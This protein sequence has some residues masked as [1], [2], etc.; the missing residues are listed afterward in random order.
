M[1]NKIKLSILDFVHIYN[2]SSVKEGIE[3]SM[4]VLAKA[5]ELGFTR[6][7]FTEHHN[8]SSLASTSPAMLIMLAGQ[9]SKRI[10]IGAGG[11]MLPNHSA[12]RIA[13]DFT[14]LE[15]LYPGR[16][17]L[18]IGR[19]PGTDPKTHLELAGSNTSLDKKLSDL[20]NYFGRSFPHKDPLS[21]ITIPGDK[22]LTPNIVMLGSS[23]G[24]VQ[25]AIRDGLSFSFAAH[26]NP[27]AAREVLRFYKDNYRPK[28]EGDKPYSI[29]TTAVIVGK[30]QEEAEYLAG[31]AQ[32]MWIRLRNGKGNPSYPSL[33]EAANYNY[34]AQDLMIK[35]MNKD[36][37]IIGTIDTVK[38]QFDKILEETLADEI[39]IAD[40][41]PTLD[42]RLEA[43]ELLTELL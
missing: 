27:P 2:D 29:Y 23:S 14:T 18:G 5:D 10:N 19:A 24:G 39:M 6:Y 9:Y 7:W 1:S 16:V 34:T 11:V 13:E 12:L 20:L 30:T 3:N 40:M 15:A 41:Y 33:E 35:D 43:L 31:P 42:S 8:A 38:K 32:L 4:S 36:R 25:Y 22:T 17:D 37:F 28:T 26:I 21:T